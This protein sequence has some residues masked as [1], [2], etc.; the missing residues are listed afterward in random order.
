MSNYTKATNFATKDALPA[1][2][3][4]KIVSGTE[5]DTEFS[6]IETAVNT[7]AD[8]SAM[9]TA[10][11]LKANTASPTFTGVP[12][13]PTAAA[14]TDTTQVATTAF[15][16]ASADTKLP[17]AGGTMTGNINMNGN[18]ITMGS[19]IVSG[20]LT[21]TG[22]IYSTAIISGDS[23]VLDNNGAAGQTPIT[24]GSPGASQYIKQQWRTS[25]G[26]TGVSIVAYGASHSSEA[27]NFAIKN[28]NNG[29]KE[30]FFAL[31]SSEPLRLSNTSATFAGNI[32][33]SGTVDGRDVAADGSKLDG[34]ATSANNY[35]HPSNHPISVITGLQSAL[36]GKVDDSQVL[37]NVPSGAV[38]TDT[39]TTYT[40]GDGGLTTH[41]FTTADHTKLN[42]IDTDA[43]NYNHPTNHA[44]SVTTG[45]QAALDAKVDDT[46]VLTNVPSGAVFTDTNTVYTHP[47]NHAISVT[48]GLQAAL[49]A[50][51]DDSQV[52]TNVPSG[53]VFT[54]TNTVYTHPTNHAISVT[55]GLQAA[56]D[57][58]VDDS[59]VLT[60][61]PSGALF[62]DTNTVYTH[63]SAHP[64]SFITGLQT[65]LNA[66]V[67]DSQVLTNV[68]SGAVF[69]DTNTETTTSISHNGS[70][71]TL[72]YVDE[73][74]TTTNINLAQYIDDTNLARL[75]SGSLAGATGIA[76]FTR[77]DSTTFTI[78]MSDLLDTDT[79]T[80]RTITDSTSTTSSTVGAS[81]TA[82][83]AA[84][85]RTWPNTQRGI[86]D[87]P[88]NGQTAESISSNWAF[89]HAASSTAH[90]RDTRNQ[91]AGT[92]NNYSH[93]AGAG[94]NHV[95][96]GGSS[97]Q[98]LKYSSSGV[99]TWATPSYTTNT[100]TTYSAGSGISLTGTTFANTSPNVVQTTVSG[101]AG[102]ATKL[103]TA[104]TLSL[105]G[106]VTGSVSFDGSANASITAVVANDS[107]THSIYAPKA[108][109]TFTGNTT[110]SNGNVVLGTASKGF[111]TSAAWLKNTTA[112]GYIE[113]GPANASWAHIYTD[114]AAF[115][116]NKDIY[117]LNQ[118]LYHSGNDG[119]GSGVDADLLD[120][121]HASAF[122]TSGHNHNSLYMSR[123][124]PSLTSNINTIASSSDVVRWN[125]VTV[126][127]P[128]SGQ[129]NE[130]GP[131]LQMAYDGAIVSQLAHD[132]DQDNLYFRQLNASTDTGGTWEQIFHDTYH[133]NA[134]KW[135]T[136]R[137][138]ALTGDVTGSVNMDGSGNV[139]IT[140]TVAN[141]S[142]THNNYLPLTGGTMTGDIITNEDIISTGRDNGNFGTYS[143]TLTD[144]IW[145]MGTSYRN[146][147]SGTN[148]GNLY[149]LAYKHT[150][151]TTGGTMGGGHQMVWCNNGVPRAAMGYDRFW[152][153][154]SGNLWGSSNDGSGSG[155][156][157]DLLD[158]QQGSYYAPA[159]HAHSEYDQRTYNGSNSYLGGYY[160]NGG[161]GQK[162]NH[163]HFGAGKFKLSMQN[164]GNLGFG[165][166]WNDV[167][168]SSSY[169][170]SDVKKSF[171]IV[172]SKYDDTSVWIAKQ[173]YDSASWGTGHLLWNSGNDGS[174]SGLDAD[175]LDGVQGSSFLRSD[176]NDTKSGNLV[177]QTSGAVTDTTTGLLFETGGSYTD[178]RYRTRFRKADVGGGIP[179]YI[180]QS[181]GTAN[182]YTTH[183]RFGTY[184]GNSYEFE[185]F[186]DINA[187]GNLYDGGN[188]VWHSGND[189]SGSG[190]DADT[191]AGTAGSSFLHKTAGNQTINGGH[192]TARL[193]IRRT[194]P[195]TA[196]QYS[197]L[198]LWA[199]EPGITHDGAGIGGNIANAGYYYGV[200]NTS[201]GKGA[202]M[203][204]YQ[205]NVYWVSVSAVAGTT[206]VK[207][208][209][210]TLTDA[211]SLSTAVQGT[212]WGATN[213]GSGSG[214]DADT[215]DGD[216]AAAFSRYYEATSAPSVTTNGTM[217]LDTSDDTLYQ[218]Q[219][220]SWVQI[221]TSNTPAVQIF[222]SAGTLIN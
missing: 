44:I 180:D 172:S 34:I 133:P 57:A 156:D 198:S 88:V 212:V 215:L 132:F 63:P 130:Y 125:N 164:S 11:A 70:T 153:A 220:G 207:T 157:A 73:A 188:P 96:S 151:N 100:N 92:Y 171:A 126:G 137:N 47:T 219:D 205:G 90:P 162:P 110:L 59:Q 52:L 82:V 42:S 103:L 56:L 139:S 76:T 78:D 189:G 190:L 147:A 206:S 160:Q 174:G 43:N 25:A 167:L 178:G 95:P 86:D 216:H 94:N 55:T 181:A 187:S 77:D 105:T 18:N 112:Y 145:S 199:S 38:F 128:A 184:S 68:P 136:A 3:A 141:N 50:K 102:T 49:D 122:A 158:G 99:A 27:G 222:N 186:G 87:V 144:Q 146:H 175:L 13:A 217:W 84:Y 148:F 60:N 197:F 200:E 149:G 123:G 159:S 98:F 138:I 5:I 23:L 35:T 26:S 67:D 65:A 150:N 196:S 111:S 61:V 54:D 113:F 201:V 170:G 28:Q 20:G 213:D 168:W 176:A 192:S 41:N 143:S 72:S 64:I 101:N 17:L 6:N 80:W 155:L 185:V 22:N 53:A 24:I 74:G 120:G 191:L 91:I 16:K 166:A 85:D 1:G 121:Q 140:T 4:L 195:A 19:G 8:T 211:G 71:R 31:N 2:N 134:D 79:N 108:S 75:V 204:F 107:H 37:T 129:S 14:G 106:D 58:K 169:N 124:T 165:G 39:N 45:L 12:S 182:S 104:R 117:V 15:V 161:T 179:L 142:H 81:A 163:S 7:K 51:V 29:G 66:K 33:V 46:Q 115:Y 152:H 118:K 221:S 62:T 30:I 69:T 131:I 83:K 218:R 32:V 127:R 10:D 208:G 114:R 194:D 48:T 193:Q 93:P 202:L 119:S 9:T 203:R 177:F 89:D 154:T 109:P 116:M 36:N 173:N 40:V 214:L 210:M 135:T 209:T 21:V 97:G 183:A